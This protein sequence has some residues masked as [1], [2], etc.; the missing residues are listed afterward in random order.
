[1]PRWFLD[2]IAT[3]ILVFEGEKGQDAAARQMTCWFILVL[4]AT[5]IKRRK[6]PS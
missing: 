5:V 6:T 1:V 3:H 4:P 2:R